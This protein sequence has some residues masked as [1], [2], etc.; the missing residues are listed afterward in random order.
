MSE[1]ALAN[2]GA[3]VV[4]VDNGPLAPERVVPRELAGLLAA[5]PP[6]QHRVAVA[7]SAD[8][9]SRPRPCVD[10]G[11]HP[12]RHGDRA[13]PPVLPDEV[14]DAPPVVALLDVLQRQ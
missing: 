1:L 12:C 6:G 7:L 2:W 3:A 10:G 9:P 13:H 5:L 14:H 4:A 8:N 11:L